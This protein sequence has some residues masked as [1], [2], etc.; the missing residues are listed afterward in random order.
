MEDKIGTVH[1]GAAGVDHETS[2]RTI[3]QESVD[4]LL[5]EFC[6][7]KLGLIVEQRANVTA[8][9]LIALAEPVHSLIQSQFGTQ[10]IWG[11]RTLRALSSE[12]NL[13]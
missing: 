12:A 10:C 13:M 9:E 3:V 1:R 8:A 11:Q 2:Q 6:V 5:V 4:K 7:L